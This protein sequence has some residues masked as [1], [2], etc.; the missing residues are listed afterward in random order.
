MNLDVTDNG[1]L[2]AL[3]EGNPPVTGGFPSQRAGNVG[4]GVIFVVSPNEPL[5]KQLNCR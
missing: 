3:C 5:D 1:V 2:H 4:F